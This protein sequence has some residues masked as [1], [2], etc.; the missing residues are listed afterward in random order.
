MSDQTRQNSTHSTHFHDLSPEQAQ[1]AAALAMGSSV[2]A[3]AIAAGVHRSTIHNWMKDSQ[4]F[5]DAAQLAL[6]DCRQQI[7]DEMVDLTALAIKT[8]RQV[9]ED[10]KASPSVRLKAAQTVLSRRKWTSPEAP[11][12]QPAPQPEIT[13][14]FLQKL[15]ELG[16][17][18]QTDFKPTAKSE[19]PRNAVCPCG[20]GLKYKRCCGTAEPPHL[21]N[22]AAAIST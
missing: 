20:S 12:T 4:T 17:K 13:E 15:W 10:P 22:H 19:T 14:E 5:R 9:M 3:A 7:Q 21:N 8:L 1:V 16:G 18:V 2:T 6:A 11:Q